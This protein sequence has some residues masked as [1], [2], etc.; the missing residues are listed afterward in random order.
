MKVL[1]VGSGGREHALVRK[2]SQSPRV[3]GIYCAPGNA[4]IADLARC[5]PI[6]SDNIP[7]L[8]TF[9]TSESIDLTLVG[10]EAPLA[11]GIANEFR[12][13][14]LKIFGPSSGA[15]QIETSKTFAK[16]LMMRHGIPTAASK[17][18]EKVEPALKYLDR[19]PV[20][21]VVKVD[22]LAQGK[23]VIVATTREQAREAVQDMLERL[24]FGDA[25][26][27]I[28][29][30]EFLDG[31]EMTL[32]AFT[33]GKTVV[34]MLPAQ[35]HKRVG[36]GDTGPNTG[37]MGAYA[38]AP[39][40]TPALCD[41]VTRTILSPIVNTLSQL[42][43]PFQGVLYAGLMVV[44]GEPYVLEFN[45]RFG[46]PEAQVVL[47][48]LKTDLIDICEAV[49]EHRLDQVRV[50]WHQ[51]AA[52]CVVMTSKGYPGSYQT[53]L[54]IHGLQDGGALS[55]V[56]IFH[57]GTTRVDGDVVTSGGRV[58]GVTAVGPGL[59]EARDKA[60]QAVRAVTFEGCHSRT[61]IANRAL[62]K[63]S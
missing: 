51:Q 13:H 54:P 1:V 28:V 6:S 15:A 53:G 47:P 63:Q 16:G 46:D 41:N 21:L 33:D 23:G 3:S 17:S 9:V 24:T 61:D 11:K 48:L 37:G 32:M 7:E 62:Q 22:G 45:A 14:K 42:G 57:A 50:D 30:E 2:I 43:R 19:H 12:K 5:V 36:D 39:L 31:E 35:D 4:G 8:R 55:D 34:P 58:L 29:I 38:P 59:A 18:F 56:E 40:G 52:V 25:G 10:P 44:R 26:R 20:P 27:R 49:A 60:Y